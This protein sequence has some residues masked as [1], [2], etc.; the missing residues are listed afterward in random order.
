MKD[1]VIS[2]IIDDPLTNQFNPVKFIL[3]LELTSF[4]ISYHTNHEIFDHIMSN[5]QYIDELFT[6]LTTNLE[7]SIGFFYEL[8]QMVK[9]MVQVN[10]QYG[11]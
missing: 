2:S 6:K 11:E 5:D 7:D 3:N 10:L 1:S 8:T 4:K 9:T